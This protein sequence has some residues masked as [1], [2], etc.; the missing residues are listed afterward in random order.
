MSIQLLPPSSDPAQL[1]EMPFPTMNRRSFLLNPSNT[2]KKDGKLSPAQSEK[3][4]PSVKTVVEADSLGRKSAKGLLPPISSSQIPSLPPSTPTRSLL[5]RI[6][7]RSSTSAE[8]LTSSNQSS[9]GK[10]TISKI[11]NPTTSTPIPVRTTGKSS[12]TTSTVK[13]VALAESKLP[14]Q[15]K[16]LSLINKGNTS[17]NGKLFAGKIE[18]NRLPSQLAV[19][20]PLQDD[21][22]TKR[23]SSIGVPRMSKGPAG[24]TNARRHSVIIP[25]AAKAAPSQSNE[26]NVFLAKSS[27]LASARSENGS[28]PSVATEVR[29][30]TES[31]N[32]A[33]SFEAAF[34]EINDLKSDPSKL[35][36]D[37]S[38]NGGNGLTRMAARQLEHEFSSQERILEGLQRDNERKTIETEDLKRK[39]ARIEESCAKIF[40]KDTWRDMVF[41]SSPR[42]SAGA[43]EKHESNGTTTQEEKEAGTGNDSVIVV[44]NLLR[45]LSPP[46]AE[47]CNSPVSSKKV[48]G[49]KTSTPK[50]PIILHT[51]ESSCVETITDR[52]NRPKRYSSSNTSLTME[53][54]SYHTASEASTSSF[55]IPSDEISTNGVQMITVRKDLLMALLQAQEQSDK[56]RKQ[57]ID[58]LRSDQE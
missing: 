11:P 53:D 54:P 49:A 42:P 46:G 29:I 44:E 51:R 8:S 58:H 28:I 27:P 57:F 25:S 30:E 48:A 56:A 38:E 5:H 17:Q 22:I 24:T 14:R 7:R 35:L 26:S 9:A 18:Q 43:F 13:G 2:P 12:S 40:G 1:D 37:I 23:S 16:S 19:N 45:T 15:R 50:K 21:S 34:E 32:T 52:T 31:Q 55:N 33:S 47:S 20:K 36:R 4:S 10:K 41:P 6:Q 3:S 39:L